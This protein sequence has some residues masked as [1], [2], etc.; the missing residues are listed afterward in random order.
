MFDVF[1]CL[2]VM[3]VYINNTTLNICVCVCVHS[4]EGDISLHRCLVAAFLAD[5]TD[6][7][8]MTGYDCQNACQ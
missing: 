6:Q 7:K 3:C 2:G 8:V 5:R 1:A 4:K